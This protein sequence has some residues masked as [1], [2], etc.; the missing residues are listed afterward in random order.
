M[1]LSFLPLALLA[2]LLGSVPFGLA[3]SRAFGGPDPRTGGSRNIGA[4]NVAR[5]T[6]KAAGLCTLLC[7]VG[8][9]I[10]PTALGMSWFGPVEASLV[11]LAA[12][13][14]HLWSVYLGFKGGK[15]VATALG[16]FLSIS[17]WA[18]LIILIVLGVGALWSG[19]MSVGSLSGCGSAPVVFLALGQSAV[20]VGVTA[21]MAAL[22]FWRH[23]ENISRLR[24]GQEHSYR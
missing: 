1:N 12:F 9:G 17:P 3:M 20:V 23:R 19:H 4:T 10:L 13:C 8:K 2:Y 15:G 14:G 16:V 24:A 22:V 5:L 6:G 18:C 7:D 11:G 21:A